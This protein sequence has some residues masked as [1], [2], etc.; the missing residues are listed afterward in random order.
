MLLVIQ[1]CIIKKQWGI[2]Y[3]EDIYSIK[4][5]LYNIISRSIEKLMLIKLKRK[6]YV[7]SMN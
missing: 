7:S 4:T 2:R 3:I 1:I 6:L 5:I